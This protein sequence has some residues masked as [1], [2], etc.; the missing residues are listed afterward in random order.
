MTQENL[1]WTIIT[2]FTIQAI[3]VKAGTFNPAFEENIFALIVMFH[4][5]AEAFI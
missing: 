3:T 1:V 5:Q 2:E 4:T